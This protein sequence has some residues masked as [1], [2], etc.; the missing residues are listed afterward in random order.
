ML[1]IA[2]SF[3]AML[4]VGLACGRRPRHRGPSP[5]SLVAR[6]VSGWPCAWRVAE[7]SR[8]AV[9]AANA[10]AFIE[11]AG[12]QW[13]TPGRAMALTARTTALRPA[14][15]RVRC[16]TV[17]VVALVF[18]SID[19]PSVSV[20]AA[21]VTAIARLPADARRAD[22]ARP[23]SSWHGTAFRFRLIQSS[24][25]EDDDFGLN[26]DLRLTPSAAALK[27]SPNH[28][29]ATRAPRSQTHAR[30][31]RPRR[32]HQSD[33]GQERRHR[34]LRLARATPMR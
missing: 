17:L 19:L 29:T 4:V 22:A 10:Y 14:L 3:T 11:A 7:A 21:F 13:S 25:R 8:S 24:S 5:C 18:G 34:R 1:G 32:R 28:R 26:Y 23:V 15:G 20:W 33:Q 2:S 9:G 12:F 31:L 16:A 6:Y 30:L 27:R